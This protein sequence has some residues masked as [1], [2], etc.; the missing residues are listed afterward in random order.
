[1][2]QVFKDYEK[3][4]GVWLYSAWDFDSVDWEGL[5]AEAEKS[6]QNGH[7]MTDDVKYTYFDQLEDG[8]IY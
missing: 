5:A 1:M 3:K 7:P 8:K 2:M 4:F 6:I